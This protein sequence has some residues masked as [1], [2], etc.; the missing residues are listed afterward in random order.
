MYDIMENI[1]LSQQ[2][3]RGWIQ[4]FLKRNR[5]LGTELSNILQIYYAVY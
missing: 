4:D 3:C 2:I 1:P 5:E